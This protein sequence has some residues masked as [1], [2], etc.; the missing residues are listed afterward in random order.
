MNSPL[1]LVGQAHPD[2]DIE[3]EN[4]RGARVRPGS[5]SA[6]FPGARGSPE[7]PG[8]LH[9]SDVPGGDL[10]QRGKIWRAGAASFKRP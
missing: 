1:L 9:L 2:R 5:S 6:L 10:A 4:A 8:R 7:H 3:R